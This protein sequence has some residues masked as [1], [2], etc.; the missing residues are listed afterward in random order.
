MLSHRQAYTPETVLKMIEQNKKRWWIEI[1][2]VLAAAWLVPMIN[3]LSSFVAGLAQNAGFDAQGPMSSD[4]VELAIQTASSLQALAPVLYIMWLSR[5]WMNFGVVRLRVL[6]DP[7][8]A[9]LIV[10]GTLI[11][12][13]VL[14][15]SLY[16]AAD[17]LDLSGYWLDAQG[18]HTRVV[19][20]NMDGDAPAGPPLASLLVMIVINSFAEEFVF[21]GVLLERLTRVLGSAHAGVWVSAGLF[22]SYHMYQGA[23]GLVSALSLGVLAAYSMRLT[24]SIWP[25]VIAHTAMNVLIAGMG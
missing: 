12:Y 4:P 7:G 14:A 18:E 20:S 19:I 5:R 24:K 8:V 3:A 10:V 16:A 9:V 11:I 15:W 17:V 25:C 2:V 6:R 21:R 1:A 23:Y 13:W 22:A